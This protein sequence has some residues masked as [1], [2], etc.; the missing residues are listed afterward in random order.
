LPDKWKEDF[1]LKIESCGI[2]K[3]NFVDGVDYHVWGFPFYNQANRM[4]EIT[5]SFERLFS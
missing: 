4:P 1:L 5:Q 2:P 3:N